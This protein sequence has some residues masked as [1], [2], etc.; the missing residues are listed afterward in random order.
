M[1][2]PEQWRALIGEVFVVLGALALVATGL[3]LWQAEQRALGAIGQGFGLVGLA[4]TFLGGA[5]AGLFL[6]TGVLGIGLL[7]AVGRSA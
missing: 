5:V 3:G 7:V 2:P 1:T 6:G 4:T